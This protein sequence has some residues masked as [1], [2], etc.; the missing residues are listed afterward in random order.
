MKI[1][2]RAIAAA[3]SSLMAASVCIINLGDNSSLGTA[4]AASMTAVQLVEDM[5]QGWNLGN[6]FDCTNTWTT[7]L[8]PTAIETAWGNPVTTEA[9]I[10]EIKKSGFNTVRIPVTWY[11]MRYTF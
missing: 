4:D 6:S 1:F 3:T 8:T 2:R 7:P 10:K 5:G 9:M 11:Q